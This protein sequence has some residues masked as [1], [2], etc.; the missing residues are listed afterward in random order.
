MKKY[1][2]FK[3][4]KVIVDEAYSLPNNIKPTSR[5]YEVKPDQIRRWKRIIEK[6]ETVEMESNKKSRLQEASTSHSG[7]K[8]RDDYCYE[9]LKEYYSNLRSLS[10]MVTVKMLCQEYRRLNPTVPITENALQKRIRRWL[11][12]ENIVQRSVT[13]VAQNTRHDASLLED[14]TAYVNEQIRSNSLSSCNVVNIDET[15]IE[16]DSNSSTT[17]ADK[18]SRTVSVRTSG[19]SNRCTVLLGV[20]LSGQKLP[21]FIIFKGKTNGRISREWTARGNLYPFTSVYTVQDRAWIDETRMTEWI[22]LV[23]KPFCI[24]RAATY[25]L[26]DECT[27]HLQGSCLNQLHS[28]GTEVDFIL[29]GYTSKLQVLDVGVNKPFKGYVREQYECFMRGGQNQKVTRLEI[30]RWIADAWNQITQETIKNSWAHIGIGH[31]NN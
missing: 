28:L 11:E 2:L 16:F 31:I 1:L 14:F 9:E 29:P 4:K 15:N 30:A 25:L 18:G 23:W 17:L 8:K 26:L 12:K 19:S 21:P 20:T 13:H 10:R 24:G 7:P 22:K 5:K 27:V 3:Q 6:E